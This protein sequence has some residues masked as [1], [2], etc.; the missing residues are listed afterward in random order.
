MKVEV[1]KEF[2]KAARK[3]SGKI[4]QSLISAYDRKN[5]EKLKGR[6]A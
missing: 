6:D 5:I 1:S 3:L 4:L 2:I